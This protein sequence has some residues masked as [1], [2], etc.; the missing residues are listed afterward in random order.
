MCPNPVISNHPAISAI[1]YALLQSGYDYFRLGRESKHVAAVQNFVGAKGVPAFFTNIKQSTCE[2]YPYWP[3]AAILEAATFC[4]KPNFE[5]FADFASFRNQIMS[6]TNIADC[7]RSN[8]LWDWLLSFPQ[9]LEAVLS[10]PHFLHYLE[11]EKQWIDEQN[12]IQECALQKMQTCLKICRELY[13]SPVQDI[14]IIINPIK[15][16]YA[17]DYHSNDSCFVFVS[18]SFQLDSVVHEFLHPVIHPYVLSMQDQ[19]LQIDHCFSN[20]DSSYYLSGDPTG[21]LNAFE[22]NA[23]RCLTKRVIAGDYPANISNFVQDLCKKT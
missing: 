18:G 10:S 3:R 2:V 23:V 17:T 5:G 16:I 4:I 6:A 20:I 1:Y 13:P 7:E 19:I 14:Q 21:K 22:E 12:R 15:C 8:D 9:A 11:W